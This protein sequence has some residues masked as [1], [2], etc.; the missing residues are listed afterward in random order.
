M[1]EEELRKAFRLAFQL[2]QDYWY[3]ADHESYIK[4]RKSDAVR[5]NFKQLM[6]DTVALLYK[7]EQ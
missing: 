5:D 6:E 2:G 1:N 4:N 7:E 3:L